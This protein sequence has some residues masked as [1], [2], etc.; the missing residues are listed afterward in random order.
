MIDQHDI[1]SALQVNSPKYLISVHQTK[2]RTIF[3]DEKINIAVFDNLDLRKYHVVLDSL[4]YP[5]Y[6]SLINYE[7]NDYIEQYN[8][9]KD[10]LKN[11][12]ENQ[13]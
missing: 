1:G 4:R 12:W 2:D 7:E 9:L 6:S 10:F 13:Y 5:R 3:P 11:I 8:N